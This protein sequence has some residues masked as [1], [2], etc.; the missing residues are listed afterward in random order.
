VKRS[1][2]VLLVLMGV[3]GTTAAA[4]QLMPPPKECVDRSATATPDG[5][6][7]GKEECRRKSRSGRW[8]WRSSGSSDGTSDGTKTGT[9]TKPGPGTPRGGFGSTGRG[10][11][12]GGE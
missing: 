10:S 6:Q 7:D 8:W 12:S 9:T 5:A 2:Q 4:H 3:A 1:S 11:G